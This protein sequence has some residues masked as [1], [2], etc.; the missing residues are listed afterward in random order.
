MDSKS[1]SKYQK[2]INF[3]LFG[4]TWWWFFWPLK[5][6]AFLRGTYQA[7]E[8][9]FELCEIVVY[10]SIMCRP[11]MEAG[12]C[13]DCGC[14]MPDKMMDLKSECSTGAWSSMT[15]EQWNE[16]KKRVGLKFLIE[17]GAS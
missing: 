6:G 15:P 5:W 13:I 17:Y 12:H 10:R 4:I 14:K 11:C 9:P 3:K 2:L 16:Y 1:D 8:I 7:D